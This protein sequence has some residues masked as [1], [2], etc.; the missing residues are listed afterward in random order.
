MD[1]DTPGRVPKVPEPDN[2]VVLA[3]AG[4]IADAY[5][6][7]VEWQRPGDGASPGRAKLTVALE[8]DW[9]P[10]GVDPV[11]F[12]RALEEATIAA[13]ALRDLDARMPAT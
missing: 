7:R 3:E 4:R 9:R 8:I 1:I 11:P 12:A 10:G 5:M 2:P 6:W 13:N